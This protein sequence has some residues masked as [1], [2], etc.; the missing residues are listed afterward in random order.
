MEKI[1]VKSYLITNNSDSVIHARGEAG[2]LELSP[3]STVEFSDPDASWL[4]KTYGF[5][6]AKIIEKE[7]I[8]KEPEPEKE[9]EHIEEEPEEKKEEMIDYESLTK[10]ELKKVLDERNVKYKTSAKKSTLV[11]LAKKS[12]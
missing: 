1:K 5:L 8:H 7:V 6:S 10:E 2:M 11:R 4:L 12:Q 9:P 3:G